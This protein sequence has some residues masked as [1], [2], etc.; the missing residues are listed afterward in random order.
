MAELDNLTLMMAIQA[1]QGQI[2]HFESLLTSQTLR[3]PE[4]IQSLIL[5]YEKAAERLREAY[6]E[7]W[8]EGS[9]LPPYSKI[10]LS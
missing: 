10:V 6:E 1:V 2:R 4:E 5:S 3:D 8:N 7:Q 9:N